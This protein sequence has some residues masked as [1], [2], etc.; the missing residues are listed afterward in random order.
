VPLAALLAAHPLAASFAVDWSAQPHPVLSFTAGD[1]SLSPPIV[2]CAGANLTQF[3]G[4]TQWVEPDP[5][6]IEQADVPTKGAAVFIKFPDGVFPKTDQTRIQ[7]LPEFPEVHGSVPFEVTEKMDG[8]SM[9]AYVDRLGHAAIC[10][11][12]NRVHIPQSMSF[13]IV[14]FL[15]KFGVIAAL[16]KYPHR[17]AL[18]GEFI[19][20]G[21]GRNLYKLTEHQWRIFDVYLCEEGRYALP[22]ERIAVL[23]KL[24][25]DPARWHV[26]VIAR[27]VKIAGK[28]PDSIVEEADGQSAIA[29]VKREG[30]VF[31][32]ERLVDGQIVHFKAVSNWYLLRH[33][34]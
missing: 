14:V 15:H 26:P 6:P 8:T 17:I 5:V 31:K 3:I 13:P 30:L 27:G 22:D 7:N 10:T 12:N 28:T 32:S 25:L 19:G 16:E 2:L 33:G 1:R 11:R 4:V 9:T 24:G 18:Q 29:N 21:I 20:P 34:L 23:R